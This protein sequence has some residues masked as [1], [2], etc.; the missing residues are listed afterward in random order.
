[1]GRFCGC[2]LLVRISVGIGDEFG[3]PAGYR[4]R[5]RADRGTQAGFCIASW[6]WPDTLRPERRGEPSWT[7]EALL[8]RS[9]VP[10]QGRLCARGK[11]LNRQVLEAAVVAKTLRVLGDTDA[12]QADRTTYRSPS[13]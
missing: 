13:A 2:R 11:P 12:Y 5:Q 1:M 8:G 9:R 7:R 4:R 10:Q 3:D 6:R